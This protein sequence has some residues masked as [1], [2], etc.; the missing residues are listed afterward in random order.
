MVRLGLIQA[1]ASS[2][3]AANFHTI[4]QFAEAGKAA[5]CTAICFPEAFL[6]GYFPELAAD[7]A[8]DRN[9]PLLLRLA[10]LARSLEVDLLVGFMEKAQEQIY[11]THGIWRYDGTRDDY[12]KTHLGQK[13]QEIFSPGDKLQVFCLSCGLR[14]G[15]QLCMETHF[16]EITQTYSLSGA[17]VVFAPHASPMGAEKRRNLWTK[18]IPARS[19]DNRVFMACCNLWDSHRFGGGCMVTDPKG[20]ILASSFENTPGLLSF[21]VEPEWI[22]SYHC[23]NPGKNHHYYPGRRNPKLYLQQPLQNGQEDNLFQL[24][25]RHIPGE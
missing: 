14:I 8:L 5:G 23:C 11:L 20:D 21:D 17:E 18:Y 15:I 7:L 2:D 10:E 24:K 19:Y 22:H 3:A 25:T 4:R 1:P 16:P 6:T 12:R 9:H 13:E